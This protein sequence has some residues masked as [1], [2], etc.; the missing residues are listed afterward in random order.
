MNRIAPHP[1]DVARGQPRSREGS[2][3][4]GRWPR[5]AGDVRAAS[6]EMRELVLDLRQDHPVGAQRLALGQS[7]IDVANAAVLQS[8]LQHLAQILETAV[9]YGLV[10]ST[11]A[12]S[13]RRRSK[14]TTV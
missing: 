9:E 14:A 3:T 6:L 12:T 4:R 5:S 13:R 7:L 11:S 8:T 2:E 10:G 1:T